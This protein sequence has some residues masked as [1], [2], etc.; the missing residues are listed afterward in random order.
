MLWSMLAYELDLVS[1][2]NSLFYP[3]DIILVIQMFLIW[4]SGVQEKKSDI[5]SV[6]MIVKSSVGVELSNPSTEL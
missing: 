6:E 4:C 2:K 3:Q 5:D 1:H